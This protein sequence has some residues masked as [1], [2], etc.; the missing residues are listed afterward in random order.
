MELHL[1]GFI[2]RNA[3]QNITNFEYRNRVLKIKSLK[4]HTLVIPKLIIIVN[5]LYNYTI[6]VVIINSYKYFLAM[7]YTEQ[8]IYYSRS[9]ICENCIFFEL[10]IYSGPSTNDAYHTNHK[11]YLHVTHSSPF[12]I[13][14]SCCTHIISLITQIFSSL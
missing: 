6:S 7:S 4:K 8:I 14:F 2:I 5:T 10:L 11:C 3:P 13:R 12:I 9:F 1:I